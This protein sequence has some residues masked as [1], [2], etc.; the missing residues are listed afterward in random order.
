MENWANNILRLIPSEIYFKG[1]YVPLLQLFITPV[2]FI[3][4]FVK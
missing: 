2:T 4:R 3:W 1:D